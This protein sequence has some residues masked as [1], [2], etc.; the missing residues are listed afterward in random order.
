M[1]GGRLVTN[2]DGSQAA[3]EMHIQ[4]SLY[5]AARGAHGGVGE[6]ITNPG[7][8]P[9]PSQDLSCAQG[10][11]PSFFR[12]INSVRKCGLSVDH[13]IERRVLHDRRRFQDKIKP[14][15]GFAGA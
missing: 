13:E 7:K 4:C 6:F 12:A 5:D 2:C 10:E 8:Q 9:A 3:K 15:F 1:M 11:S 14:I